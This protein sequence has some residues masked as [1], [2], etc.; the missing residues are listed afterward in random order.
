MATRTS[1]SLLPDNSTDAHFRAWAGFIEDTLVTTGGWVVTGDT[2]Q[3]APA[4]LA[5]PTIANTKQGYRVYRMADTL[6]GTSPVF[7]RIDFGST[8]T[9]NNPGFWV[10]IGTGS[11]GAG[12]ITGIVWNGGASATPNVG[13]SSNTTSLTNN[14][15]G[16]ADTN[17]ASLALF[18]QSNANYHLVFCIERTK[19]ATGADT[20]VGLLIGYVPPALATLSR[21]RY[22]V[23]AGG[24][25]P[26]EETGLS[27][28]LTQKNP[29]ETFGSDIGC[30][31]VIPFKGVAQQPG[32]NV[33]I[34]NSNDVSTEGQFTLTLYSSSRTYQQLNA[35]VPVKALSGSNA[36]DSNSRCGI[37]YD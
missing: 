6:Q 25:Q 19:D 34:V 5:H 30:G 17:R 26:T 9:I 18:V 29:S 35:L 4:S 11:D 20:G 21:S 7:M 37:R 16:S 31:I 32:T 14:S 1:S 27:Y 10:T 23:L 28:I 15:Y 33:M 24:S 13:N 22:I 3:T 2:G 12:T 36:N 8:A